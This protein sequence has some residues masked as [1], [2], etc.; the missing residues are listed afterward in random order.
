MR[1]RS[2]SFA[3]SGLVAGKTLLLK[4]RTLKS[5]GSVVSDLFVRGLDRPLA[6]A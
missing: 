6:S 4:V 3:T 5:L 1:T 2:P